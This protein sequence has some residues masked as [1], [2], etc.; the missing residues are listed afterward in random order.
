MKPVLAA[1]AL[2]L[3]LGACKSTP[4]KAEESAPS[5]KAAGT[6]AAKPAAKPV[7]APAEAPAPAQA[8]KAEASL[9]SGVKAYEDGDYRTA[10]QELQ[11]ALDQGLAAKPDQVKAN[12]YLA[13]VACATGKRDVCK[14]HFRN[15]LALNPRFQLTRAEAGH[16][17]WGPVFREARGEAAKAA[18][19]RK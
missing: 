12:K 11:I 6:T 17:G 14:K 18:P 16:P 8:K 2:S 1:L 3:A 7:E 13:F 9:A 4:P 5:A 19:A 10:Q 15:A